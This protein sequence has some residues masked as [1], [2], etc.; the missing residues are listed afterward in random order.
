MVLC[1]DTSEAMQIRARHWSKSLCTSCL[2]NY[3]EDDRIVLH[4]TAQDVPGAQISTAVFRLVLMS[5]PT[6]KLSL[7]TL[8]ELCSHAL[9][10]AHT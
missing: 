2:Q 5:V 4:A 7:T 9:L 3:G 1:S 8:Q 10:K 6:E